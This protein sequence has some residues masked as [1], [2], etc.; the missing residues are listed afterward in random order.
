MNSHISFET[1]MDSSL[2]SSDWQD[3][4]FLNS[5]FSKCVID[6]ARSSIPKSHLS[7]RK[8]SV[9]WWN[10][11]CD[12]AVRRKRAAFLKMKRSFCI[13]DVIQYKRLRSECRKMI[14][15]NRFTQR[16]AAFRQSLS[17]RS[18]NFRNPLIKKRNSG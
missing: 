3:V 9:P 6:A 1:K 5:T 13:N 4:N 15:L 10:A 2:V 17:G 7:N 16:P 12:R 14:L 18:S 11:S 8:P